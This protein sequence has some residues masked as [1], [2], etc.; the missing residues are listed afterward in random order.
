[1]CMCIPNQAFARAHAYGYQ[2]ELRVSLQSMFNSIISDV[3]VL[4]VSTFWTFFRFGPYIF[5]LPLL[6]SKI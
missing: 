1:M 2:I 6:V 5:I 3:N 4:L